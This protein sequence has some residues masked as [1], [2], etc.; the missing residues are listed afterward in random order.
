MSF[1]N[2]HKTPAKHDARSLPK[3]TRKKQINN[4]TKIKQQKNLITLNE[5]GGK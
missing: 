1:L 3:E 4:K 2:R 5:A